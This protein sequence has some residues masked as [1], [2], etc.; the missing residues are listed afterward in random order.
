[1]PPSRPPSQ[2]THTPTPTA[3]RPGALQQLE[4][5]RL[6]HARIGWSVYVR[7]TGVC[8]GGRGRHVSGAEGSQGLLY[9]AVY[10][11]V[12]DLTHFY[13]SLT[14]VCAYLVLCSKQSSFAIQ[15][16]L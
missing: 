4:E 3:R 5:D 14:Y 8:L 15:S 16:V 11:Y 1:M 2:L 12:V 6:E 10:L 9:G 13:V 7:S